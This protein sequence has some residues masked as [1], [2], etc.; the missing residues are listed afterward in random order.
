MVKFK[1]LS[2]RVFDKKLKATIQKTGKLGFGETEKDELRLSKDTFIKFSLDESS[3]DTLL[4]YMTVLKTE[5]ADGFQAKV[6]SGG[7]YNLNTARMFDSLGID[8]ADGGVIFDL[9]RMAE[10]DDEL[11]GEVYM[12]KLRPKKSTKKV[13]KENDKEGGDAYEE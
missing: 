4:L 5:D 12:M 10:Y 8:Y 3:T 1:T 7:Y 6:T 13:D 9:V 11:G 2:A